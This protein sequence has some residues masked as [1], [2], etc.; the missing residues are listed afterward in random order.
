MTNH[1]MICRSA[2][3]L[4]VEPSPRTQSGCSV[5][6][7]DEQDLA[8]PKALRRPEAKTSATIALLIVEPPA[9]EIEVPIVRVTRRTDW[10]RGPVAELPRRVPHISP[11]L[12]AFAAEDE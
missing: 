7:P 1:W 3:T 2:A 4:G 9:E 10:F 5:W 8:R 12:L 11:A 6:A